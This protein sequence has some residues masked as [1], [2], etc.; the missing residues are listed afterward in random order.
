M[1]GLSFELWDSM[2]IDDS[3]VCCSAETIRLAKSV[4]HKL[5]IEHYTV[6]VRD[7]FYIHVIENFCAS[8][9][10]GTT[11]NPCILCNKYIKFAFLMKK[12]EEL[13]A[14]SIVTGH[15][16]NIEKPQQMTNDGIY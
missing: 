6:D 10:R 15:Y 16:A 14:D 2:D 5:G 3:N 12:A 4:A 7:D 11:P 9:T 1:I 8:Y 13:G